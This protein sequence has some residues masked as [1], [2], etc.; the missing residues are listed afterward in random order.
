[1]RLEEMKKLGEQ[2]L[3]E[4]GL[5]LYD[6]WKCVEHIECPPGVDYGELYEAFWM[7]IDAVEALEKKSIIGELEQRYI[8]ETRERK[9]KVAVTT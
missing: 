1:M 7:Y 8:E 9:K 4:L 6:A 5:S 2:R 3:R